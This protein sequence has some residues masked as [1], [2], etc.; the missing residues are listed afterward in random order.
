MKKYNFINILNMIH[1]N[2]IRQDDLIILYNKSDKN[3][4]DY[5]RYDGKDFIWLVDKDICLWE[6]FYMITLLNEWEFS[7][8]YNANEKKKILDNFDKL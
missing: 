5:Y 1:N 6:N 8:I 7:V 2:K 4:V 3:L